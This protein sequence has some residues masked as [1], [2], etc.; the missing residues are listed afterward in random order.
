MQLVDLIPAGMQP[1]QC[2]RMPRVSRLVPVR[3]EAC[4]AGTEPS[5]VGGDRVYQRRRQ[6]VV[7]LVAKRRR[8]AAESRHSVWTGAG[9]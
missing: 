5:D 4:D 9:A 3:V 1:D 6:A 2:G 8:P 7:R